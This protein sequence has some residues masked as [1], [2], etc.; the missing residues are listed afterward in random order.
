MKNEVDSRRRRR[1]RRQKVQLEVM[2]RWQSLIMG[3]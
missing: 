1:R 2:K 3:L